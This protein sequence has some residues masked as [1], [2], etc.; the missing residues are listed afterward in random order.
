MLVN[1]KMT[2][3]YPPFVHY[4]NNPAKTTEDPAIPVLLCTSCTHNSNTCSVYVG[5]DDVDCSSH[6]C[7]CCLVQDIY[8]LYTCE[9]CGDTV[10]VG[11]TNRDTYVIQSHE[12]RVIVCKKHGAF[13]VWL[14]HNKIPVV[15]EDNLDIA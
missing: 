3:E 13:S 15:N 7:E 10:C 14:S 12:D 4:I 6:P 2:T 11:C 1:L 9:V 8:G 5:C